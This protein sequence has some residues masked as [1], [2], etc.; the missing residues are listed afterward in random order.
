[1]PTHLT[2]GNLQVTLF[3]DEE[4]KLR[5][6]YG[7]ADPDVIEWHLE[8][9]DYGYKDRQHVRRALETGRFPKG[10]TRPFSYKRSKSERD[11]DQRIAYKQATG[12]DWKN[13][14]PMPPFTDYPP[15]SKEQKAFDLWC[16]RREHFDYQGGKKG[17]PV[18]DTVMQQANVCIL[19]EVGA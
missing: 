19:S 5:A 10:T 6:E 18:L 7:E 2:Y 9:N 17:T 1:M 15:S 4:Q 16:E 14:D 3:D 12:R 8:H 11:R 13:V